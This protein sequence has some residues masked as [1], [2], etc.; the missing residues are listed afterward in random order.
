MQGDPFHRP[1]SSP[2]QHATGTP[3]SSAAA[4]AGLM[5]NLAG[6]LPAQETFRAE[7]GTAGRWAC[8]W[9][10][11]NRSFMFP[12]QNTDSEQHHACVTV[13]GHPFKINQGT[14]PT[15]MSITISV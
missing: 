7:S 9:P 4:A 13:P 6:N 1:L 12:L 15:T 3:G 10:V 2:L 5:C 11:T 14:K 8:E